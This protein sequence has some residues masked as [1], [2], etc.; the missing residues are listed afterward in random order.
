MGTAVCQRANIRI[1][2]TYSDFRGV[3]TFLS[4][5]QK[6]LTAKFLKNISIA[7]H[8]RTTASGIR[9]Y[10]YILCVKEFVPVEKK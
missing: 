10:L 7:K 1:K 2:R 6:Q 4:V 8:I 3:Y 5:F 9:K